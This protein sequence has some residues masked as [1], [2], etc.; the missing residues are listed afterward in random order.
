MTKSD[1]SLLEILVRTYEELTADRKRIDAKIGAL[2]IAY[3]ALAGAPLANDMQPKALNGGGR[4]H[5]RRV[6][7]EW[8]PLVLAWMAKHG[9]PFDAQRLGRSVGCSRDA[10]TARLRALVEE[11]KAKRV[12]RGLYAAAE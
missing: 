4:K 10:A 3:E 8:R 2:N 12:Q 7:R 1:E 9:K 5:P 11:G 6:M